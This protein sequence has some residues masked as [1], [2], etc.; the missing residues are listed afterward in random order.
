MDTKLKK[1]KAIVSLISFF[2]SMGILIA[3]AIFGI[4]FLM[5]YDYAM[6]QMSDLK[7]EDYQNTNAFRAELS[8]MLNHILHV[9]DT[10]S[11]SDTAAETELQDSVY[12]DSD[13]NRYYYFS[14]AD[15]PFGLN[16]DTARNLLY[17]IGTASNR[18]AYSNDT[19]HEN[20]YEG[21][22]PEGYNFR[23][24]FDGKTVSIEKDGGAVDVYGD[25]FY[26]SDSGMW[27]VPGYE[28]M[29]A[30][31]DY[32]NFRVCWSRA[33]SLWSRWTVPARFTTFPSR[34]GK[35]FCSC[36]SGLA[37]LLSLLSCWFWRSFGE[38]SV[39]S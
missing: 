29:A 17:Q 19:E 7:Q 4:S 6:Q 35:R 16:A 26:R 3:T 1:S 21:D 22:L 5:N 28:N 31:P 18:T 23:L 11:S 37:S 27:N 30:N 13:G 34:E 2:L 14:D 24:I 9:M 32:E 20:L 33:K 15:D 12:S 8:Q 25:G 36:A 38:K 10:L 39:G